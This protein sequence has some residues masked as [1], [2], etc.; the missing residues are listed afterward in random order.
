VPYMLYYRGKGEGIMVGVKEYIILLDV[1]GL[2]SADEA[3]ECA[4]GFELHK[5]VFIEDDIDEL[6]IRQ[7]LIPIY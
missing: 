3:E 7:A 6:P 1:D 4:P 5:S 2:T